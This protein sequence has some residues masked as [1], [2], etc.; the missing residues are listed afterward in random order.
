MTGMS[1]LWEFLSRDAAFFGGPQSPMLSWIGSFGIVLFFVWQVMRLTWE[2]SS[3]Q[4]PFDRVRSVLVTLANDR[5]EI[6]RDRFTSRELVGF[7]PPAG[8]P[9]IL[10]HPHR[11]RRFEHPGNGPAERTD[12]SAAL[13]TIPENADS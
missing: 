1:S 3:A 5:G 12:V 8:Q 11:L 7:A 6:D 4:R 2:V 9:R 10:R 13:G